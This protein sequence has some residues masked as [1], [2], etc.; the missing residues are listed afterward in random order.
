[1]QGAQL[2]TLFDKMVLDYSYLGASG[3]QTVILER[4]LPVIPFYHLWWGIRV[5]ALDVPNGSFLFEAANTLPSDEDPAEFTTTPGTVMSITINAASG[6]PTLQVATATAA[7]PFLRIRVKASQSGSVAHV[8]GEF[9]AAL[10]G[11]AS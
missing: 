9:S 5:H 6:A 2:I 3:S 1:M 10:Y 7:G 4:A 11:R 8:Y